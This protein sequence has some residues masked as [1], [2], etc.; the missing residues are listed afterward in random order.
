MTARRSGHESSTVPTVMVHDFSGHPFQAQLSRSL[1]RRG[2]HTLHVYCSSFQTPKG[3][4]GDKSP[5]GESRSVG[6]STHRSFHKYSLVRRS[7][8]EIEYALRLIRL[9][10]EERPNVIITSNTPLVAALILHVAIKATRRPVVFWQQDIYSYAMRKHFTDRFGRIGRL[11]G[12]LFV[13]AERWILRTSDHVVVISPD[14]ADVLGDWGVDQQNVTVIPNWAPLD[15]VPQRSRPNAWSE[16]FQ[17]ADDDI[18][19]LYAGTLG[20]KH[21]PSMLLELG[22]AFADRSDVRVIVASEG[23]GASWLAEHLGDETS[24]ELVPFQPYEDLPDM[25]GSGDVMLVL[26]EPH[27]G[28]FS[29]PSKVLTYHCAGRPILAAIPAV[30][31]AGRIISDNGSGLVV[32]PGDAEQFVRA[33]RRLVD[34]PAMRTDMSTAARRYAEASFDIDV[35]TDRFVSSIEAAASRRRGL[36]GRAYDDRRSQARESD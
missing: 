2:F 3:A 28:V 10:R 29:V 24:L 9:I 34:D 22:R 5:A 33:A 16:K 32:A 4:V 8:Q 25:L 18:V 20:L 15:E 26:L 7:L 30:N 14:F 17:I 27:A 23:L 19:L 11:V 13:R 21:E 1:A 31:L 36:P 6:I 35:I 12:S